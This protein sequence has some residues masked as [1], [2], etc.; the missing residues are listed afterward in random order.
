MGFVG[1]TDTVWEDGHAY[2]STHCRH[3]HHDK[4]AATEFPGGGERKP[5]Q[6]KTCAAPCICNC[7]Q[8]Q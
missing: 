4:C 6:C 1:K 7:H 3:G 5:S 8:R 2:W